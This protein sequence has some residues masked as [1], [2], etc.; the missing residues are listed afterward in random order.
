MHKLI[1]ALALT[2]ML[3]GCG[4]PQTSADSRQADATRQSLDAADRQIGMPRITNFSQRKMLKNAYEDMDQTTLVY[5]YTQALDGKFVCMGQG[6]GYG[7]S[8]GTQFTAPT[9]PQW[10]NSGLYAK[11]QAE[12]NGLFMPDSGSGTTVNLI[13]PATGHAHTAVFEPNIVT[14]PFKLPRQAVAV[15]C[16]ADV[17]PAKVVDSKETS[18]VAQRN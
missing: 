4:E 14:V 2:T 11:P 7:I 13:D 17:D 18:V 3:A 10:A 15:D 16:P 5:V 9:T 12:P 8:M 1:I 6:L